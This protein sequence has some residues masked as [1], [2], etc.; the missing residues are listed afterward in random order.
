[1]L[2]G[3]CLRM[4]NYVYDKKYVDLIFE[5]VTQ[6]VMLV[7]LFGFMDFMIICK[8]LT[9]WDALKAENKQPPGII[10]AMITMFLNGGT[11]QQPTDAPEYGDLVPLQTPLMQYCVIIAFLCV[12]L[13][14][15]V[16]PIYY[17]MK[18]KSA[19]VHDDNYEHSS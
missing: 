13:M 10:M 3:T 12:P 15:L 19:A 7:V 4:A 17:T 1:M 14:L 5:A 11:Y 18:N 2:F 16:K 8:W 9:D 6:W